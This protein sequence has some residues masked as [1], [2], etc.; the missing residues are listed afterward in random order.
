MVILFEHGGAVNSDKTDGTVVLVSVVSEKL[1][2]NISSPNDGVLDQESLDF[3]GVAGLESSNGLPLVG[4]DGIFVRDGDS[5]GAEDGAEEFKVC[6]NDGVDGDVVAKFENDMFVLCRAL[7]QHVGI[8]VLAQDGQD[9]LCLGVVL[10]DIGTAI[11]GSIVGTFFASL[12]GIL[13]AQTCSWPT[14]RF[15]N[16]CRV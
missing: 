7:V 9:T 6:D 2:A 1:D 15:E 3:T 16:S 12:A 13:T 14:V 11:E 4:L 5:E 10:D 8:L